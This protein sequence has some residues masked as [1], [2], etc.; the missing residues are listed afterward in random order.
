MAMILSSRGVSSDL[1]AF[2]SQRKRDEADAAYA[3]RQGTFPRFSTAG[4]I[5]DS[6]DQIRERDQ[7][8]FSSKDKIEHFQGGA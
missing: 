3:W 2:L 1:F 5:A 6:A 7:I 4:T 8:C